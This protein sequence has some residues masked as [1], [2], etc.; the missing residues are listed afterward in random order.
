MLRC[1][2]D[3]REK[4]SDGSISD[5]IEPLALLL[6]IR[7]PSILGTIFLCEEGEKPAPWSLASLSQETEVKSNLLSIYVHESN[8]FSLKEHHINNFSLLQ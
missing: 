1:P 7:S 3:R 5:G 4:L 2:R 8:Y 6:F